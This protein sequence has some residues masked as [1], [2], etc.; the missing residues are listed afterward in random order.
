MGSRKRVFL[1]NH[2]AK[3]ITNIYA[4]TD[5]NNIIPGELKVQLN[6][7]FSNELTDNII[8][9]KVHELMFRHGL[10]YNIDWRLS[11]QPFITRKGELMD[12]VV[13]T[14][15]YYQGITPHLETSGGTSDGRFIARMGAQVLDFG[16][17]NSTIHS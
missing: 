9:Q 8:R 12:A 6:F 14:V 3:Q 11:G 13:S 17:V 4:G 5:S 1:A 10:L 7:R 15:E 16:P 2:Y